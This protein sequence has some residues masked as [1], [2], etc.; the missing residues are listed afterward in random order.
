MPALLLRL[1][2]VESLC[3]GVLGAK[4]LGVG[5]GL[6]AV[7]LP[8]KHACEGP[9]PARVSDSSPREMVLPGPTTQAGVVLPAF[10]PPPALFSPWTGL[11][12]LDHALTC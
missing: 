5:P 10:T 3:F 1:V 11:C 12:D 9:T 6:G 7:V 4:W 8:S 2:L